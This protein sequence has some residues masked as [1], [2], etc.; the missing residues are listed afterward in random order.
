MVGIGLYPSQCSELLEL[1]GI[2]DPLE[3]LK[4]DDLGQEVQDNQVSGGVCLLNF[5]SFLGWYVYENGRYS[6]A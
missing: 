1:L 5:L 3:L 6:S 4:K 2:L